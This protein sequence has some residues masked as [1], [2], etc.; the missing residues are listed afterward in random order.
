[1]AGLGYH[2][3]IATV[4]LTTG[5]VRIEEPGDTWY[6]VYAGGGLLG[7]WLLL[8]RTAPGIDAL[9]PDNLLVFASSAIAGHDGPGLARFSVITKSPLSGG[10]AETRCEGPFGRYLKGSGIDALAV[11]GRA[12]GPVMLVVED[13]EIRLEDATGLW[14]RDTLE[15]AI[16]A[17]SALGRE[18]VS[19]AAIGIAG[20]NLVR[21][22]SIVTDGSIQAQRMGTGAV[23]GAKQLKA[24]ALAGCALPPVADQGRLTSV[25]DRFRASMDTNTLSRFQKDPPGFA[26]YADLSDVDTA[27]MG[28]N[29]YT[30]NVSRSLPTLSRDRFLDHYVADIPCPGCPN[31]CIK[32][33]DAERT[34]RR[35][36]TR[37]S[38]RRS[39]PTWATPTWRSS[40]G[41]TTCA[42]GWAW[43]PCRSGSASVGRWSAQRRACY[44]VRNQAGS[45]SGSGMARSSCRSSRRSRRA[46]TDSGTSLRTA[47]GAVLRDSGGAASAT[48]C[49]SRASRW[50]RSSPGR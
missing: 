47:S 40:C 11:T 15:T 34:R 3:R 22:A 36:S 41:S 44:R 10:I 33:I 24:V 13:G 43:T 30:G 49:T 48:R 38:P 29:N 14:G 19:V 32:I 26:A 2:G 18:D 9:G 7:A 45:T 4:N 50:C 12:T 8:S 46:R 31:D 37:R 35:G 16:A 21:Y 20:E 28:W 6:R 5:D 23:M 25:A 27:Y 39:G 42:T 1:M 17:R